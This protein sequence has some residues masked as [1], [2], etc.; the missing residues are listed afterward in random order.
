VIPKPER[1]LFEGYDLVVRKEGALLRVVRSTLNEHLRGDLLTS[2]RYTLAS[3]RV[4]PDK[5]LVL[6]EIAV[7]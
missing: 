7:A 6:V 4:A 3:T 1:T 2:A 5:L